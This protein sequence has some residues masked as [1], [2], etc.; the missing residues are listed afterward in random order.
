MAN[1]DKYKIL[2]IVIVLCQFGC[3]NMFTLVY[4]QKDFKPN[5]LDVIT[6]LPVADARR[7]VF[8]KGNFEKEIEG[9]QQLIVKKLDK[10]G[11][12]YK[13]VTGTNAM[14]NIHPTQVP[15][16]DAERISKI[17]PSEANWILLPVVLEYHPFWDAEFKYAE[18]ACYL[19]EKPTGELVWEGSA[20]Y[21]NLKGATKKLMKEFPSKK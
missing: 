5:N 4:H 13:V 21:K 17:G 20:R 16:L 9:L 3:A 6:V 11:Y 19:F 7:Q 14:G 12:T 18:I 1:I 15:F 10:K 2:F 8:E